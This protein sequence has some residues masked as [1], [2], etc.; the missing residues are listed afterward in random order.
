MKSWEI[1]AKVYLEFL[2]TLGRQSL[3]V[4]DHPDTR[5][6]SG[7][8]SA[9]HEGFASRARCVFTGN[10]T[11]RHVEHQADGST[12]DS[13]LKML[14]DCSVRDA[15]PHLE[16]GDATGNTPNTKL[17]VA[18]GNTPAIN[19][20][21]ATGN[22]P[23]TDQAVATGNIPAFDLRVATGNTPNTELT[24]ATGNTAAIDLGVATGNTPATQAGD[25]TGIT[26]N[27]DQGDSPG[28]TSNT[29]IEKPQSTKKRFVTDQSQHARAILPL[30][31]NPL[32]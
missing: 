24:V 5:F 32:I 19:Q 17:A 27:T 11:R 3:K 30:S 8:P 2:H 12:E 7:S 16:L 1:I 20:S 28:I 10:R 25:S 4:T 21:V 18:T 26:S 14:N 29:D 6:H 31:I 9:C 22:T 13:G 23:N 15:P